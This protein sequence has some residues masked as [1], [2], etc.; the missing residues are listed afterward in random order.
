MP[1]T[2]K[3]PDVSMYPRWM[4][5]FYRFTMTVFPNRQWHV[6]FPVSLMLLTKITA[7]IRWVV[8]NTTR[9]D[10]LHPFWYTGVVGSCSTRP[11][12]VWLC[13]IGG[14]IFF[15]ERYVAVVAYICKWRLFY[16]LPRPGSG[17][18]SH[19]VKRR[20]DGMGFN[21]SGGG[22]VRTVGNKY[23]TSPFIPTSQTR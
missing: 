3:R 14:S 8:T 23:T 19:S 1:T 20:K 18:L 2:G 4:P 6:V 21:S 13:L 10:H 16:F 9:L 11:W 12:A 22:Y 5:T 17:F 7:S 15:G